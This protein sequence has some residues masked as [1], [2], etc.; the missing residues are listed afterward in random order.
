MGPTSRNP[1]VS[2]LQRRCTAHNRRGTQCG[3]AP[4]P[5]GTV[6]R[7]HGGGAPAVKAAAERRL[8]LE[9]AEAHVTA[10]VAVRGRLTLREVY[11]EL[12]TTATLAVQWRDVLQQRVDELE[13]WRYTAPGAGTEQTRAELQLFEKALDRT[14]RVLELIARLDIDQRATAM[15]ARTGELIALVL[16][17]ALNAGDLTGAQRS[18]IED[19][20][21]VEL[22]R[23]AGP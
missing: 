10:S 1:P 4:I 5:G 14:S 20:L 3:R 13:V 15:D 19:A 6:C 23:V 16:N 2:D 8:L 17:R 21:A 12:L 7:H 9:Q 22:R 11:S 18:A